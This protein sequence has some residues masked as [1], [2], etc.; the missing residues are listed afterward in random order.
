M[1]MVFGLGLDLLGRVDAVYLLVS[2]ALMFAGFVSAHPVMKY[3]IRVLQWYPL[4]VWRLVREAL[5]PEDSWLKLFVFLFVFN[6]VSLFVNFVSGWLVVLPY[7]LVYLLGL[8]LGVVGIEE[9]GSGGAVG[10]LVLN[11]VAWLELPA[12]FVATALGMQLGNV[13]LRGGFSGGF[14]VFAGFFRVFLLVVLPLLFLAGVFEASL[15]RLFAS[16]EGEV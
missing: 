6:S 7:L 5:S 10:M 13:V 2:A 8:N 1:G 3:D 11:P 4:W 16:S 15:I 12:A 14:D 9:A